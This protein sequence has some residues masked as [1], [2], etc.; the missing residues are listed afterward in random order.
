[1]TTYNYVTLLSGRRVIRSWT[2]RFANGGYLYLDRLILPIS[3]PSR[4]GAVQPLA[5]K[6]SLPRAHKSRLRSDEDNQGSHS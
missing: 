2:H 4:S 5:R 6:A 1:M 3:R